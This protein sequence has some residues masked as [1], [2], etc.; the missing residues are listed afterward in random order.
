MKYL[1]LVSL[2]LSAILASAPA[3][4]H[5]QGVTKSNPSFNCARARTVAERAICRIPSLGA[6]DRAI[7]SLYPRVVAATPVAKRRE[8]AADQALFNRS[9]D[10]CYTPEQEQD[11]C[12][13]AIM[14]A[15]VQVLNNWLRTG[16]Q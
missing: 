15:R 6:K 16:F 7:A 5:A 9:R 10:M 2:S 12:L 13:E 8:L 1:L 3:T 4:S 11:D 14:T